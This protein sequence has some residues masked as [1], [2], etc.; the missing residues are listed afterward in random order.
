MLEASVPSFPG[1][2]PLLGSGRVC[3]ACPKPSGWGPPGLPLP[4]AGEILYT[5]PIPLSF[6]HLAS[7]PL[8]FLS[9]CPLFCPKIIPECLLSSPQ[10]ITHSSPSGS[11]ESGV[12]AVTRLLV[13]GSPAFRRHTF[14]G[15]ELTSV[16]YVIT[17]TPPDRRGRRLHPNQPKQKGFLLA[18]ARRKSRSRLMKRG[19]DPASPKC[20]PGSGFSLCIP[21]CGFCF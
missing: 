12:E 7:C 13:P 21:L 14:R 20:S 18:H 3:L 1:P 16:S 5:L 2:R 19:L 15:K 9:S 4:Y 17:G 6:C 10:G 8:V 11:A